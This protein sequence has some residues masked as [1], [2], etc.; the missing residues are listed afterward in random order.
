MGRKEKASKR[1]VG[2]LASGIGAAGGGRRLGLAAQA[3]V[4]SLN[5]AHK[6]C[7]QATGNRLC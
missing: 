5:L 1:K 6:P 4:Q 7:E 3:D 2:L